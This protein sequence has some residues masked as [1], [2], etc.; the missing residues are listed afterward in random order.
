[1]AQLAQLKLGDDERLPDE[2]GERV[3]ESGGHKLAKALGRRAFGGDGSE[4]AAGIQGAAGIMDEDVIQRVAGAK[5]GF[6]FLAGAQRCHLAQMHD[7]HAITMALRLLQIMRGEEQRRAVIGPHIHE[8]LPNRV[9]RNRV[10]PDGRFIEEEH[11]GPMQRGLGDFQAANHAAGVFA[12]HAAGIGGQ[13]HELQCLPDARLLLA[14]RQVVELRE[15]QQVLVPGERT[16]HRDR[17]RHVADDAANAD[18]L[19]GDGETGHA[20]LARGGRQERGEHLDR[21]GLARPVGAEQ[22]EDLTG[23]DRK[24]QRIHRRER[25][26]AAGQVFDFENNVAHGMIP[27][28]ITA[29]DA[30]KRMG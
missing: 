16:V 5:R 7:C 2:A 24:R 27:L 1:M 8:M 9:A 25:A 26:E 28:D 6:E 14:A 21:G 10:Q 22:A 3:D 4:V 12:H 13:V 17:L 15:D 30:E 18:R 11:F 23:V 19:R 29:L 20:R